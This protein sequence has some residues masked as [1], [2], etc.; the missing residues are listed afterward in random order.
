MR[1][2]PSESIALNADMSISWSPSLKVRCCIICSSTRTLSSSRA[3]RVSSS[4]L[5]SCVDGRVTLTPKSDRDRSGRF[6][7]HAFNRRSRAN[8]SSSSSVLS[9][10]SGKTGGCS[11]MADFWSAAL[12]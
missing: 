1:P 6:P 4:A 8:F 11:F 9:R 3:S 5:R 2:E 7:H 10:S 12:S